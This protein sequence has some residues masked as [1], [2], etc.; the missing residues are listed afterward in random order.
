MKV[1]ITYADKM[2]ESRK[3]LA[4]KS[5]SL[6]GG[7]DKCIGYCP[8]DIDSSFYDK[9]RSILESERGG[10]Y[11]LWKPYFILKTLREIDEGDYLFYSDAGAFLTGSINYLIQ[12]MEDT[13]QDV[14]GFETPLIEQQWTKRQVF[15]GLQCTESSFKESNH[16]LASYLLIKKTVQSLL[17]FEKFLAFATN[18]LYITDSYSDINQDN[19]FIQHRHDQSIFSLLYKKSGYKPFKDPSQFGLFPRGFAGYAVTEDV[20]NGE[21]H[22]LSNGRQFRVNRRSNQ[23]PQIIFHYRSSNPFV[24]YLKHLLGRVLYK[25]RLYDGLF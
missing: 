3:K 8:D 15:D 13:T 2:F 1:F 6:L 4:L 17:F 5:A 9:N 25:L 11:W 16:I 22:E 18:P 20:S 24:S 23:Y 14:M 21:L 10:G 12:T 19:R 7:F